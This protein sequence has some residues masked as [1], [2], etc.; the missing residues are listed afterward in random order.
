MATVYE[1]LMVTVKLKIVVEAQNPK[2]SAR[3]L[4]LAS[5]LVQGFIYKANIKKLVTVCV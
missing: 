2:P 1:V 3:S 4:S 5:R